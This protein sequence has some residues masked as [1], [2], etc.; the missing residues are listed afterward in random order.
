MKK[1]LCLLCAL[2]LMGGQ[3]AWAEGPVTLT[4]FGSISPVFHDAAMAQ[5]PGVQ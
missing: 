1:L 2:M 3:A 5:L 4:A